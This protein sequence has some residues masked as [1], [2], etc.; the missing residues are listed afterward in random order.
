MPDG[1]AGGG[2]NPRQWLRRASLP[3]RIGCCL[4]LL[5]VAAVVA[6][7]VSMRIWVSRVETFVE[8]LQTHSAGAGRVVSLSVHPSKVLLEPGGG[9]ALVFEPPRLAWHTRVLP[10]F[11]VPGTNTVVVEYRDGKVHTNWWGLGD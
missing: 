3:R 7:F 2:G 1:Q 5:V 4:P 8:D 10:D 6:S 11:R 9:F